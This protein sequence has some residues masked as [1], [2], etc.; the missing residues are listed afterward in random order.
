MNLF[1]AVIIATVIYMVVG[2][3]WY[4]HMFFGKSWEKANKI[5]AKDKKGGMG[6]GFIGGVIIGLVISYF[7]ACFISKYGHFTFMGGATI[8]FWLWLGFVATTQLSGVLWSKKPFSVYL[9]DVGC[10]LVTFIL[11]GG[12]LGVLIK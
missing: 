9:V 11:M 4:S 2:M 6:K 12:V 10:Y 8:A 3:F 5:T 1:W 7:L